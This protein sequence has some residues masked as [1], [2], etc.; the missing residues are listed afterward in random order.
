VPARRTRAAM[1][2]REHIVKENGLRQ[3]CARRRAAR[4][5]GEC[6]DKKHATFMIMGDTLHPAPARS[7]TSKTG[8][9]GALDASEPEACRGKRPISSGLPIVVVTSVDPATILADGGAEH[10]AAGRC[11]RSAPRC[12]ST[13]IEILTPDFLRQG[14]RRWDG[15]GG[16]QGPTSSTHNLEKPCR[17][18]YLNGP[19]RA[20]RYFPLDPAAAAGQGDRSP[21]SSPNPG[22]MFGLGEEP[23]RGCWQVM[24][25]PAFGRTSIFLTIGQYLWQADPQAHH[26]VMRYIPPD[27][28]A[29]YEKVAYAKGL[30]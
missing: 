3:R 4:N 29:S 20:A 21:P 19:F 13:T 6:W 11:V 18:R 24:D 5:I 23:P 28:F 30:S 14:R 25:D 26:A 10:F 27:E 1:P 22:I 15:R 12:S 2:T 16:G 17:S 8:M 7:A 9:P